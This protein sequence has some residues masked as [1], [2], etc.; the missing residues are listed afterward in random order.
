METQEE[1]SSDHE[2][3]DPDGRQSGNDEHF[4]FGVGSVPPRLVVALAVSG[5]LATMALLPHQPGSRR[6]R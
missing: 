1:V 4:V 5:Q 6:G 3:V 2:E